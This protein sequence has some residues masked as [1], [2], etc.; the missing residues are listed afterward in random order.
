MTAYYNQEYHE[1]VDPDP[2]PQ[3][4]WKQILKETFL[5]PFTWNARTSRRTYWIGFA[6]LVVLSLVPTWYLIVTTSLQLMFV[7][8][9]VPMEYDPSFF[10]AIAIVIIFEVY[11]FLCELGLAIRRLHDINKSGYWY[12]INFIPTI[13]WIV[14]VYFLIQPTV[15]EPVRWG[16]Y[17]L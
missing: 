4:N 9:S 15:K 1:P 13:G 7:N 3:S 8:S 14:L 10:V 17:L 6:I 11:F 16:S 12:W 2:V 5:R